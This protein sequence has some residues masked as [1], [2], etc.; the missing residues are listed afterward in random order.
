MFLYTGWL[1][2]GDLGYY[3]EDGYVYLVDRIKD[4]FKVLGHQISPSEIEACLQ[5]HPGVL[6]AAVIAVPHMIDDNHPMAF[7]IQK[8]QSQVR[9]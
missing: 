6:E 3:D 7:I 2:S 8:E 9:H 5:K 4:I 1:H